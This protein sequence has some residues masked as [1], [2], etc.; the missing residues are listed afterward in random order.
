M[1]PVRKR[2]VLKLIGIVVCIATIVAILVTKADIAISTSNILSKETTG[3]T[4]ETK[5]YLLLFHL[6]QINNY[7]LLI[8]RERKLSTYK[9]N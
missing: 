5:Q 9:L 4:A 3:K 2:T 8:V 6:I 1:L 7:P